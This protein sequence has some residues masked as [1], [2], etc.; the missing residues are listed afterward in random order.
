MYCCCMAVF[1]SSTHHS[2]SGRASVFVLK[3]VCNFFLS[4]IFVCDSVESVLLSS[5]R[6]LFW[7]HAEIQ[8]YQA[9]ATAQTYLFCL[10]LR[11][12][13]KSQYKS[14]II[15]SKLSSYK[16]IRAKELHLSLNL[17]SDPILF[18]CCI[19]K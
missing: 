18:G 4:M 16:H 3:T 1:A 5:A 11:S 15:L 8:L 9:I 2:H 13:F 12:Q 7:C 10:P 19:V 6:C 17:C 14:C